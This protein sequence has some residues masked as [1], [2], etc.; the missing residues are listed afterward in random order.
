MQIGC[1]SV[2]V[3]GYMGFMWILFLILYATPE[4]QLGPKRGYK[5]YKERKE[6]DGS[7]WVSKEVGE[8][9]LHLM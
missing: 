4:I 6:E 5:Y 9:R 1:T 8:K 3:L 7:C 2:C